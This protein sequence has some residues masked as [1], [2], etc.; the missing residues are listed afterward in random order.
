M[1]SVHNYKMR[2]INRWAFFV[3]NLVNHI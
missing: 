1:S 2:V 3:Y